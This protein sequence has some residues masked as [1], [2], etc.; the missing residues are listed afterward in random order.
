MRTDPEPD[1]AIRR[2][3][4]DRT[5]VQAHTSRIKT[6]YLLEVQRGMPRIVLQ[7]PVATVGQAL[8]RNGKGAV[9][10]PELRRSMVTQSFV[11]L[12]AAWALSAFSPNASSFPAL[13][14]ASNCRSH[15]SA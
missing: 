12:P 2:F 8:N 5:M 6:T 13:T 3:D 10:L 14:S 9:A 7:L 11:V 1:N 15:A 4:A